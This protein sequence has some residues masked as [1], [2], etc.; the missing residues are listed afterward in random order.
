VQSEMLRADMT[1]DE[2]FTR[3][4][5][6]ILGRRFAV[7]ARFLLDSTR[8]IETNTPDVDRDWEQIQA[9]RQ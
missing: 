1:Y 3:L 9:V 2:A 8:R 7:A 4:R 5:L 6:H